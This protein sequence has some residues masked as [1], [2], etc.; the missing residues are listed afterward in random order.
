MTTPLLHDFLVDMPEAWSERTCLDSSLCTV[1]YGELKSDVQRM[2]S[3]LTKEGCSKGDRIVVCLPK[4]TVTVEWILSV[5]WLGGT[6]VPVDYTAPV[7]RIHKI[8][9]NADAVKVITLPEIAEKL[10]ESGIEA[11]RLVAVHG[12]EEPGAQ[13]PFIQGMEPLSAQ[14]VAKDDLAAFLYTSGSTG[15]PKGVMLSHENIAVFSKWVVDTYGLT[16][17]D[18]LTSHAPFHFDL[19]TMDLYS[20]FMVGASVYILDEIE[21]RFPSTLTKI[22]QKKG[23]TSW[24]SVPSALMLIE[25]KGA[26]HKRDLSSLKRIFFA[27]EVY[28][29]PELR[30]IMSRLPQVTF[31]NLYGPTETNV[32]TYYTMPGIPDEDAR[33]IPIGKVCEHY[34]LKILGDDDQEL[35]AGEMGEIVIVGPGVMKGYWKAEEKTAA[36]RLNGQPDSYRTGDFGIADAEGVV[37]YQGR[38]DSQVK[39]Q[40]YRVELNEIENTANAHPAIK[41]SVVVVREDDGVKEILLA[42]VPKEQTGQLEESDILQWCSRTLPVY[43]VPK[44]ARV[45][46]AFPRTSTGKIDR[47]TVKKQLLEDIVSA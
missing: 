45:F 16:G 32:C 41:E 5:L 8:V 9:N 29:L 18:R 38:K 10:A 44:Q 13:A 40:G 20:A 47:Q 11:T 46:S 1:S 22:I 6:Y 17:E 39:I 25:E 15:D 35:P 12:I 37:M 3:W 7:E 21:K 31:A 43:A 4:R 33:A 27:G 36:A 34:E 28:P 2:S 14:S 42:V 23:I 24:Y 19:S 30:K 26:L